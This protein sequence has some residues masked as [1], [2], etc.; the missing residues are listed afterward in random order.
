MQI[1]LGRRK[2]HPT[3]TIRADVRTAIN[4][5]LDLNENSVLRPPGD[6]HY[7][8]AVTSFWFFRI[9]LQNDNVDRRDQHVQDRWHQMVMRELDAVLGQEEGSRA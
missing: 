5:A 8:D 1:R 7:D 3:E 2:G 6:P 9:I 4:R